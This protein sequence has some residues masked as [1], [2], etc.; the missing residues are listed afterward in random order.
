MSELEQVISC[1]QQLIDPSGVHAKEASDRLLLYYEQPTSFQTL[2][3]IISMTDNEQI[4]KHAVVGI[5]R[6]IRLY[7]VNY[8]DKQNV[9][10]NLLQLLSLP[11]SNYVRRYIR[12]FVQTALSNEVLPIAYN[13]IQSCSSEPTDPKVEACLYLLTMLLTYQIDGIQD[14]YQYSIGFINLGL[15]SQ[16]LNTQIAAILHGLNVSNFFSEDDPNPQK[17]FLCS[18]QMLERLV[19]LPNSEGFNDLIQVLKY[20]VEQESPFINIVSLLEFCVQLMVNRQLPINNRL[21]IQQLTDSIITNFGDQIAESSQDTVS[22]IINAYCSLS[23]EFFNENDMFDLS[24]HQILSIVFTAF[25]EYNHILQLMWDFLPTLMNSRAGLYSAIMSLMYSFENGSDFYSDKIVPISQL[26]INA[27]ADSSECIRQASTNAII[28]LVESQ[29]SEIQQVSDELLTA[30][31]QVTYKQPLPDYI[32]GIQA[33]VKQV[34]EINQMFNPVYELLIKLIQ[35]NDLTLM[36]HSFNCLYT[37][38]RYS[39]KKTRHYFQDILQ[40]IQS[41]IFNTNQQYDAIKSTAISCLSNL[42]E[43]SPKSFLPIVPS[44]LT[45]IGQNI[46]SSDVQISFESICAY[47]HL[48]QNYPEQIKETVTNVFPI[49]INI[50]SQ[51]IN[52]DEQTD[53]QIFMGDDE[54]DLDPIIEKTINLITSAIRIACCIL[55]TY[56]ELISQLIP[57]IFAVIEKQID[58]GDP[59]LISGC[60]EACQF[61]I[62]GINKLGYSQETQPYLI[63]IVKILANIASSEAGIEAAGNAFT[64]ISDVIA[65]DEYYGTIACTTSIDQIFKSIEN[66]FTG[67]MLYQK[68]K[69]KYIE[70]LHVPALRVLRE[71]MASMKTKSIPVLQPFVPLM[72]NL[73]THKNNEMKDL[74]LQFFGDFVY[75]AG[76]SLDNELKVNVFILACDSAEKRNSAIAFGCFKQLAIKAP[77]VIAPHLVKI[78]TMIKSNLSN[79]SKTEKM[80][81]IQDNCVSALA[82]IAMRIMKENFPYND[83]ILETLANMPPK[84]EVEE[85]NDHLEFFEWLLNRSQN[86]GLEHFAAVLIRLFS[87]PLDKMEEYSVSNENVIKMRQYLR[88]L[89]QA[90][91]DFQ[92]LVFQ[93]CEGDEFKIGYV[94]EA[95]N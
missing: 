89:A 27:L 65:G 95:L 37:L 71:L 38:I 88:N 83:F 72:N 66:V 6:F 55:S 34:K 26:L 28:E 31:I 46:T 85:N 53:E 47:G 51:T 45:F 80:M 29:K 74:A 57:N 62:E 10:Q 69:L 70:D 36:I 41:I 12:D 18:I 86:N 90:I 21:Q 75:W 94:L 67:S 8:P 4:M 92:N 43:S 9:F 30:L 64:G 91:P 14:I 84:V 52:L 44:F 32:N 5:G 17:Y 15:S 13:F 24:N 73:I 35:T 79:Q 76:Q 58:S 25:S 40:L 68:G 2:I 3:T 49:L 50:G 42:M 33:I 22:A 54:E 20:D 63:Q 77:E 48:L 7:Y 1:Y 61:L 19:Q 23:N 16:T 81:I 11:K 87:D 60:S 39:P 93:V 82:M 59:D 78:L 56:P